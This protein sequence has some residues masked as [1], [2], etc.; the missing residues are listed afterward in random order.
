MRRRSPLAP[1]KS[2]LASPPQTGE[3]LYPRS[4]RTVAEAPDPT[5]DFPTCGSSK[6][7]EN[8]P[9]NLTLRVSRI[10]LQNFHRSAETVR[11][12]RTTSGPAA[13]GSSLLLGVQHP[14]CSA[15]KAK[16]EN[17]G[18][19]AAR[20]PSPSHQR[21]A[22][23]WTE[24]WPLRTKAGLLGGRQLHAPI[25]TG[26]RIRAFPSFSHILRHL[27]RPAKRGQGLW[28]SLVCVPT[29]GPFSACPQARPEDEVSLYSI[30]QET[31]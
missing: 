4:S 25:R 30:G 3:Q 31:N 6:G 15:A 24:P 13:L 19:G 22:R 16:T 8:P 26:E 28:Q 27:H 2:P 20:C 18:K 1:P 7:P 11:R 14:P 23:L 5:T 9:G 12:G 29:R 17:N 21:P 10:R